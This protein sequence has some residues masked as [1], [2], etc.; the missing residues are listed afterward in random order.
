MIDQPFS[1]KIKYSEF[2]IYISGTESF[3]NTMLDK[4]PCTLEGLS[5]SICAPI[6]PQS[7]Y[8]AVATDRNSKETEI[9]PKKLSQN[10][11]L[12]QD[13]SL[14]RK[15]IS[16]NTDD[17]VSYVIAAYYIQLR[18]K[19]NYFTTKEVFALLYDHGIFIEKI[20]DCESKNINNKNISKVGTINKHNK[21]RVSENT[22]K[23][24]NEILVDAIAT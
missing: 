8:T 23:L 22:I 20:S 15:S 2:E 6:I 14:W 21:Y 4:I 11:I 24:I 3:I 12:K 9:T 13:F 18:N 5:K 19:D 1:L 10:E 16:H 17:S 7:T